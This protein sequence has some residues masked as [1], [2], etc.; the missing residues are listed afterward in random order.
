VGVKA[1]N[2]VLGIVQGT[3]VAD[4]SAG[5]MEWLHGAAGSL[6]ARGRDGPDTGALDVCG[7]HGSVFRL[8]GRS[9]MKRSVHH[10]RNLRYGV[11]TPWH[12]SFPLWN[13]RHFLFGLSALPVALVFAVPVIILVLVVLFVLVLIA[14][15]EGKGKRLLHPDVMDY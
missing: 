2:V 7:F 1:R 8:N 14:Q 9:I 3:L 6:F 13:S 12:A 4:A 5:R 15:P 10:I 11:F